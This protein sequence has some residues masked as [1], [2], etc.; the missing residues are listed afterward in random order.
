[1]P[2]RECLLSRFLT[3]KRTISFRPIRAIGGTAASLANGAE[4]DGPFSTEAVWKRG[5][6]VSF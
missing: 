4:A 3:A 5:E 1:V 6:V 2:P